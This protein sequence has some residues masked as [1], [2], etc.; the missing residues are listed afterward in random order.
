MKHTNGLKPMYK[1]TYGIGVAVKKI[2]FTEKVLKE[3][4]N[5]IKVKSQYVVQ[6]YD[7][8]T[9]DNCLYIQMELCSQSLRNILEV[10]PQI[11]HR[12]LKPENILIAK[13]LCDFGLAT[14][15]D[16][17]I[18]YTTKHKHTADVG[19]DRYMAPEILNGKN[20]Q[21]YSNSWT[22][23]NAPVFQLQR[24]LVS[25]INTNWTERPEC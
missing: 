22:F 15:H 6:Y 7:S 4:E 20:A 12:D 24:L 14:V 25:M 8:W 18:H 23:L 1:N 13:N 5:L 9:T 21:R 19:D 16:K 17:R 2:D 11:I 3:V 10:K